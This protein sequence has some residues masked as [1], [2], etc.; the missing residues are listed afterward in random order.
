MHT[1]TTSLDYHSVTSHQINQFN[2]LT[3]VSYTHLD[4]YK[5]QLYT[6][7][8]TNRPVVISLV[9]PLPEYIFIS[10]I[11]SSDEVILFLIRFFIRFKLRLD[12][13][14]SSPKPP[15]FSANT[16]NTVLSIGFSFTISCLVEI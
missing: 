11:K 13:G 16:G 9:K 15:T 3:A 7:P 8:G 12:A 10:E 14:S 2:M 1:M 6:L 4:V 5:R